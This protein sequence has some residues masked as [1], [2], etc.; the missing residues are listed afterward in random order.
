[1]YSTVKTRLHRDRLT[2]RSVVQAGLGHMASIAAVV[3]LPALGESRFV[4]AVPTDVLEDYRKFLRGRDPLSV[5]DFSGPSTRRDVVE[6]VLLQQ[7]LGRGGWDQRV[8][9]EA[10]P[11]VARILREIEWAHAACSGTSF[12]RED[13]PAASTSFYFS[14][15]MV[16]MGQFEAGLYT[17]AT[18]HQAMAAK[19][20]PDVQRLTALSNRGWIVDWRTLE[21]LGVE[22]L[23]HVGQWPAM[24]KMVA[25]GRADFLLAPFQA[26]TDLSLTVDTVRLVP[27]PGLKISL[28][29]TRHF[30]VS[31]RHARAA[32]LLDS[33]NAGL[34][35]LRQKGVIRQAYAQSGFF[36]PRVAQWTTLRAPQR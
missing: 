11:N 31:R 33:L 24:P 18:N 27:I 12:W 7:A 13:I 5:T 17:V 29:G 4:V 9:L 3:A 16:E 26:T 36:N 35:V 23:Q 28:H 10:L 14:D 22:H 20:L 6:V 25:G 8:S 34:S 30:L 21:H 1:M 15:A 19:T 32:A 2:R